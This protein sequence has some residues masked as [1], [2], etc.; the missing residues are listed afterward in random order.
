MTV[1][2]KKKKFSTV[3]GEDG[4][5]LVGLPPMKAGGPF[6]MNSLSGI[7]CINAEL[8]STS[9]TSSEVSLIHIFRNSF[10]PFSCVLQ[11]RFRYCKHK[12]PLMLSLI[13]I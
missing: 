10:V 6:E 8:F 12:L 3:A 4:K 11:N 9:S 1:V 2:F 5:W 13:H 7:C